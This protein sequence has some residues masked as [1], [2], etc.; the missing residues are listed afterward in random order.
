MNSPAAAS[1]A[2]A[3]QQ[4][5]TSLLVTIGRS[6]QLGGIVVQ[7]AAAVPGIRLPVRDLRIG[8][9]RRGLAGEGSRGV[10]V[11]DLHGET[12]G[13][14]EQVLDLFEFLAVVGKP[15]RQRGKRLGQTRARARG[16]GSGRAPAGR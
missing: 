3:L 8:D 6:Q 12:H 14:D 4:R 16:R 5:P 7:Q 9:Q 11:A 15:G 1:S 10:N 13:V 2:W